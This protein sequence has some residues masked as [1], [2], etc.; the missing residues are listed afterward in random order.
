MPRR[1]PE[2]SNYI[3]GPKSAHGAIH[4]AIRQI[5]GFRENQLHLFKTVIGPL[6]PESI[7]KHFEKF[8][9]NRFSIAYDSLINGAGKF[10]G[11]LALFGLDER[12]GSVKKNQQLIILPYIELKLRKRIEQLK[13]KKPSGWR[14]DQKLYQIYLDAIM[15]IVDNMMNLVSLAWTFCP[16]IGEPE[17][18]TGFYN[19]F[20]FASN[21]G[22]IDLG[23]FFNCAIIAYLY[24]KEEATRRGDAVERGQR[25]LRKRKWLNKMRQRR[26]IQIVTNLLW[27]YATSA[28]TI[29][30]RAS[31]MLGI[32]LGDNMR[33]CHNDGKIIDHLSEM[34]P[35]LVRLTIKRFGREAKIFQIIN[36][37]KEFPQNLLD[38]MGN[39]EIFDIEDYMKNLF[40]EYDAMDPIPK[41]IFDDTIHFYNEKYNSDEW[42]RYTNKKWQ[43]VIPQDLWEQ[44]VRRREKFGKKALPIKIQLKDSGNLVEPYQEN[45]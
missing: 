6:V 38:D 5:E 29:E 21:G 4:G 30:D 22:L 18:E 3:I 19:R 12:I 16:G 14:K 44:V 1:F 11:A 23:H 13:Q 45:P 10:V 37:I 35:K 20:V 31:D 17:M 7:R 2:R 24:G 27:G 42:D 15:P 41:R 25:W 43:V 26:L 33:N 9:L 39:G 40:E 34:Y 8:H 36:A 28:D 32:Y